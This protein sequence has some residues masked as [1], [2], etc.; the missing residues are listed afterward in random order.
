MNSFAF[1]FVLRQKLAGQ[2][3]NLYILEQLPV[4]TP[5][6]FEERVG[7]KSIGEM[8]TECVL[9]L[10]YT[11]RDLAGFAVDLGYEGE[12]FQWDEEERRHRMAQIDA[13][14]FRLYGLTDA[15]DV[16]YILSTFPIIRRHDEEAF[17]SYRTQ[18]LILAYMRAHDAGDVDSRVAV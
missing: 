14:M 12:P 11:A 15:D 5:E 7:G 18:D 4:P 1:D 17:G 9:K 8:V 2:T 3:I 6:A 16:K 10:S 13:L